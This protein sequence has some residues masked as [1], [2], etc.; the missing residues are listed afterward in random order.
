MLFFH[1]GTSLFQGWP[2]GGKNAQSGINGGIIFSPKKD[3]VVPL[4]RTI[5]QFIR[6][7]LE[8]HIT[9]FPGIHSQALRILAAGTADTLFIGRGLQGLLARQINGN[10]MHACKDCTN[11]GQT[12]HEQYQPHKRGSGGFGFS[13][14]D[15]FSLF[16]MFGDFWLQPVGFWNKS[17]QNFPSGELSG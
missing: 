3:R 14:G 9:G 17:G 5:Q 11:N 13:H 12:D 6:I 10:I 7:R 2:G 8:H 16:F 4:F 15:H 1:P